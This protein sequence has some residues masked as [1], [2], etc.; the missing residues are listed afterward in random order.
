[1][2]ASKWPCPTFCCQYLNTFESCTI[3]RPNFRGTVGNCSRTTRGGSR[4]WHPCS[5]ITLFRL[6]STTKLAS[7][8][9]RHRSPDS[10]RRPQCYGVIGVDLLTYW[11]TTQNLGIVVSACRPPSLHPVAQVPLGRS[12]I[13]PRDSFPGGQFSS[14]PN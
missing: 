2:C 8:C 7:K 6:R 3:V 14:T 1:M 12:Q 9:T 10:H 13:S 11:F 4:L 5:N